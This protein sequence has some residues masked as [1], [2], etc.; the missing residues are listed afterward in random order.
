MAEPYTI[1]VFVPEGDP[2]GIRVID[3]MNWTGRGIIFPRERWPSARTRSDFDLPGVYIL[4]GEVG[5]DDQ[6]L[7]TIYI[8]EGDGIRSR[9]ERHFR[10]KDFWSWGMAFVST[11]SLNKAH[12]QW[13]EYALVRR[14]VEAKRCLLDNGNAPQPPALNESEE[15]D[16]EGFLR[17]ILQILPLAGLRALEPIRAVASPA[18]SFATPTRGSTTGPASEFDTVI[19]PARQNGFEEVFLGEHQWYAI[20]MAGGMI[21]RIKWIAAYQTAPV[22][23]ITHVAPVQ[24]IE[25]YGEGGKYRLVFSEPA[26]GITPIPFG[27]APQGTM[28][29][30]RYV[31]K[32]RLDVA[33]SVRELMQRQ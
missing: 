9:I 3:R 25:P 1:R 33:R 8:G 16:C 18:A 26:R 10:E 30:P 29:G 22:S 12:V 20:R 28:Q 2:E 4:I 14:A 23:A 11:S 21:P 32:A 6:Q 5:D 15:A 24:R 7:P 19:V 31:S 27:D 13:L 17:E